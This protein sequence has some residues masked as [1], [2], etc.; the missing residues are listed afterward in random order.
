MSSSGLLRDPRLR[1]ALPWLLYAAA[2]AATLP[3]ARMVTDPGTAPAVA[4]ARKVTLGCPLTSHRLWV[5]AVLVTPGQAVA[6]GQLLVRMAPGE[7]DAEIA[8]A[9]RQLEELELAA[10]R[11]GNQLALES[12][13]TS[14]DLARLIADEQHD[15][16]ELAEIELAMAQESALVSDSLTDLKYLGELKRRRAGLEGRTRELAE[17]VALARRGAGAARERLSYWRR[18]AGSLPPTSE[19]IAPAR[20]AAEAQRDLVRGLVAL[21]AR[22]DLKAPFAGRVDAVLL[23]P[24]EVASS[25]GSVI[26]VVE[27]RPAGAIA[28][29]DE[30]WATR[31]REGDRVALSPRDGSALRV[32]GQVAALGPGIAE[33]PARFW[34]VPS[35][36]RYG[37]AVH[38]RLEAPA[39]LPG[40]ALDATFSPSREGGR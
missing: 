36:P 29:V 28:Y 18:G 37:R 32:Q 12:E 23:Q 6:A 3:V 27:E 31:V 17:A 10:V 4:E 2:A 8:A 25:Q 26:T 33:L 30:R 19:P 24:G 7:V 21:R 22:L 38:V 40:Q 39:F 13:R 14:L 16:S 15:R 5:E 20:A 9:R 34:L 11:A 35:Q 1:R